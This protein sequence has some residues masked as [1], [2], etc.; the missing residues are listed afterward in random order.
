M[1]NSKEL[2]ALARKASN[3]DKKSFEKLYQLQARYILYNSYRLMKNQEDA[4]DAA[5]EIVIAMYKS[6]QNLKD[7]K[8]FNSWL[9]GITIN[10]CN[11]LLKKKIKL[12]EEFSAE[13]IVMDI[14]EESREFLPEKYAEDKEI[15]RKLIGIIDDLPVKKR[16]A[17][18]MYYYSNMSYKEIAEATGTTTSTIATNLMKAKQMIKDKVNKSGEDILNQ[19]FSIGTTPVIT[20]AIELEAIEVFPASAVSGF[21]Q[22]C[23]AVIGGMSTSLFTKTTIA[24]LAKITTSQV[25]KFIAIVSVG[26]VTV[27]GAAVAL[28]E[29]DFY[30]DL[31]NSTP[32]QEIVAEEYDDTTGNSNTI[33]NDAKNNSTSENPASTNNPTETSAATNT[34]SESSESSDNGVYS[35]GIS[36]A[37]IFTGGDCSCGHVNPTSATYRVG[38]SSVGASSAD[39]AGGSSSW[40]IKKGGK[41]LYSG[42]SSTIKTELQ[43]LYSAKMDGQYVLSFVYTASSGQKQYISKSFRIDTGEISPNQYE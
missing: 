27:G 35:D 10:V 34:P 38:A 41:V 14:R 26:T 17:I 42:T 7:P 6:I 31:F 5:Q 43:K 16:E 25:V 15:R 30:S 23:N 39:A 40:T 18:Y 1:D 8:H 28:I 12:K 24:G 20:R 13:D 9:Y 21:T 36:G 33:I 2:I 29:P 19:S 32:S 3:G 4:E 11:T 37:V 22:S